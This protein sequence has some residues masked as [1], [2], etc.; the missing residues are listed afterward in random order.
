LTHGT[1]MPPHTDPGEL[2]A[3]HRHPGESVLQNVPT[4]THEEP[5][6]ANAQS[7][8]HACVVVVPVV[9]VWHVPLDVLQYGGK[10]DPVAPLQGQLHAQLSDVRIHPA[11]VH[12]YSHPPPHPGCAVVVVVVLQSHVVVVVVVVG[13]LVVVVVDPHDG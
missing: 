6:H 7:P 13:E 1:T 2:G 10:H 11:S 8:V 4:A 3:K 5:V 9:V 12:T